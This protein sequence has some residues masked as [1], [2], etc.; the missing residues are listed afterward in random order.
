M[1]PLTQR[2]AI[3]ELIEQAVRAAARQA[4]ACQML[5][6]SARTVQ[7][8]QRSSSQGDRRPERV[9]RPRNRFTQAE[10]EHILSVV[11]SRP[12]A[13]L[14]PA[15]IVPALADEGEYLASESSIYRLLRQ[16]GQMAR[17]SGQRRPVHARPQPLVATAPRQLFSW[18]ITYLPAAVRGRFYYL[19]LF[20][21]IFSRHIIG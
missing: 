16:A 3:S 19:Y 14:P 20:V 7:R 21:D 12:Y 1:S 8:W 5:G 2:Q 11:N 17:R 6:I 15:Q 10:R 13:H 18:D 9:Q 4:R